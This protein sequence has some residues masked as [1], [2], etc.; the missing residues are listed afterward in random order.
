M[1]DMIVRWRQISE[2][3]DPVWWVDLLTKEQ[4]EEGFGS[5]TPMIAGQ[6]D[7][8]RYGP[9]WPRALKLLKGLLPSQ[10]SVSS[11]MQSEISRA[12]NVREVYEIFR[13]DFW[14]VTPCHSVRK[15]GKIMEGT[16]LTL[17]YHSPEGVE[18][19]IRTPGTPP[20]WLEYEQELD[21]L[22]AQLTEAASKPEINLD[23]YDPLI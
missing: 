18:F 14:V 16:R 1:Y 10:H 9:M 12:N 17:Q 13:K 20:R 4:F 15:P 7:V 19:S 11:K 3:N 21:F 22:W 8:V 23:E 5:H 6:S 2:P